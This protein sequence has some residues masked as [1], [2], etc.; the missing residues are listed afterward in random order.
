M[1]RWWIIRHINGGPWFPF[2]AWTIFG[3]PLV[4]HFFVA[5]GPYASERSAEFAAQSANG[6][7]A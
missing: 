1:K 6:W 5:S 3:T 4:T 7:G 2:K